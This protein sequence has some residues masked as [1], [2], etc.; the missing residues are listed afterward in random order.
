MICKQKSPLDRLAFSL[1]QCTE[2]VESLRVW[3]YAS[4]ANGVELPVE[5]GIVMKR[6]EKSLRFGKPP[7]FGDERSFLMQNDRKIAIDR[8]IRNNFSKWVILRKLICQ[9]TV[10]ENNSLDSELTGLRSDKTSITCLLMG[11]AVF[12]HRTSESPLV[13][14]D[15]SPVTIDVPFVRHQFVTNFALKFFVKVLQVVLHFGDGIEEPIAHR[16]CRQ[17]CR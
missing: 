6:A 13:F 4:F 5:D 11:W 1:A 12:A 8:E 9:K 7:F 17:S 15:R 14:M 3:C 16:T 2:Y 10:Y